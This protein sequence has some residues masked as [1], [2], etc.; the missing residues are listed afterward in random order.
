MKRSDKKP[1]GNWHNISEVEPMEEG[2][3]FVKV[4]AKYTFTH[5]AYWD[6]LEWKSANSTIS[7]AMQAVNKSHV[8]YMHGAQWCGAA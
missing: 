2:L 7:Y 3:Y 8:L 4:D 5:Y 6:G 1:D